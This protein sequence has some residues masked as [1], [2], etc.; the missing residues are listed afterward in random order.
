MGRRSYAEFEVYLSE[1]G[2][3]T[4]LLQIALENHNTLR[5]LYSMARGTSQVKA[6][7]AC[8]RYLSSLGKSDSEIAG[9]WGVDASSIHTMRRRDREANGGRNGDQG[10]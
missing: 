3:L 10:V 5:D 9:I 1:R 6:R 7:W 8:W 2:M 4:D